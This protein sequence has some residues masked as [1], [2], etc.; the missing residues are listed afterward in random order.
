M[1]NRRCC[2]PKGACCDDEGNCT[3]KTRKQCQAAGGTWQ[4]AGTV[5]DPNPCSP[6]QCSCDLF[7][8]SKAPCCFDVTIA[9]MANNGCYN[10]SYYNKTWHVKQSAE[11]SCTWQCTFYDRCG[12]F[13]STITLRVY[14]DGSSYHVEVKLKDHVWDEDFGE[15]QPTCSSLS[16][17]ISHVTDS[18]TCSSASATCSITPVPAA[19]NCACESCAACVD[20][21]APGRFKVEISGV[22]NSGSCTGCTLYNGTWILTPKSICCWKSAPI[23]G[24]ACSSPLV[25]NP[26]VQLCIQSGQLV[27]SLWGTSDATREAAGT[28]IYTIPPGEYLDCLNL[29]DFSSFID[30]DGWCDLSGATCKV[31]SL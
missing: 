6:C 20:G 28:F 3:I 22:A 30:A 16:G 14:L 23:S 15:D 18:G 4:G 12:D 10:C 1:A 13:G 2:R 21:K 26:F 27:V 7:V 19:G 24:T 25:T 31:T 29:S 5:C 9:G 11:G 17:A 8:D